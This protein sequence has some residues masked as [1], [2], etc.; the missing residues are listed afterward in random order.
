LTRDDEVNRGKADAL[1]I[2][3]GDV[4]DG[5]ASIE[6]FLAVLGSRRVGPRVLARGIPEVLA[7]CTT[8]CASLASLA[9][10]LGAELAADP[11]GLAATQ[12]LLAHAVTRVGELATV[13][14]A[15]RSASLDARERLA[16]EAIVRRIAGDLGAVVRLVDLLGAAVTSETTT[17]DLGDAFAQRRAQPRAGATPIVVAVEVRV[18]DLTVGDARLMLELLEHAVAIVLR[19]GVGRPGIVVDLGPDGF[20]VFAIGAAPEGQGSE[21]GQA[22]HVV[23]RDELP[24]ES[25]VVRAA[26]RHAGIEL[27]IA[28]DRRGVTIAL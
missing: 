4:R 5:V 20:P 16:L 17:I 28:A 11:A 8:L 1:A 9:P 25:D 10:A 18:S 14:A 15:N 3:R 27:A 19:A 24:R 13:L 22:M 7:G 21:G 2:A 23:L 6:H 26:A 12:E